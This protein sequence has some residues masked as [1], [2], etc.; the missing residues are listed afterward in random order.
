MAAAATASGKPRTSPTMTQA[1]AS[2]CCVCALTLVAAD[3]PQWR[4]PDRTD[5]SKETGLLKSWPAAGP[6]LQWTFKDAGLGY[7]APAIVGER[8][9]LMGAREGNEVVYALDLK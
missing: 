1:S 2:A 9:Y 5:V 6:K 8:L 3:W 7:S 4:G